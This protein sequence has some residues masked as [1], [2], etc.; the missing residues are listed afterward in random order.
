MP[1]ETRAPRLGIRT[2]A[3]P[4]NRPS[5]AFCMPIEVKSEG[6]ATL[7]VD[8]C[9]AYETLDADVQA[10]VSGLTGLHRHGAGHFGTMFEN[11]LDDHQDEDSV[12]AVHPV[13]KVHPVSGKRALYLNETHSRR[14]RELE[15]TESVQLLSRLVVH[16]ARP[17]NTYVHD[18]SVGDLL[19]W[20]QRSTIHWA[21]GDFPPDQQRV[22]VRAIV[23]EFE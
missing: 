10:R 15:P 2:E 22:K 8:M 5:S 16:A 6:E 14:F 11:P 13:V 9:A 21:A 4:R 18:W 12:Y 3:A 1:L 17:D 23:E 19:I 20:D 7:F